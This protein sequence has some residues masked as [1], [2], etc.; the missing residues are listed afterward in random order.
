MKGIKKLVRP[1]HHRLNC[2]NLYLIN[3]QIFPMTLIGHLEV[4]RNFFKNLP[5]AINTR[6]RIVLISGSRI[7]YR[8]SSF[9]NVDPCYICVELI[10]VDFRNQKSVNYSAT[11]VQ[12]RNLILARGE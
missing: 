2:S 1:T 6:A 12:R 10:T 3:A 11:F 8:I 5:D 9:A 4:I 7:D